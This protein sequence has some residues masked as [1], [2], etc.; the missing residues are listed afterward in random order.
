MVHAVREPHLLE[1]LER[2]SA[3]FTPWHAGVLGGEHHVL[4]R[5]TRGNQAVALEHE[6]DLTRPDLV[7]VA[8]LELGDVAPV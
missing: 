6:T 8:V 2:L 5:G 7:E 4:E 3:A 1:N